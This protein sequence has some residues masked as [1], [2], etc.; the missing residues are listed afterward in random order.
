MR[1]KYPCEIRDGGR[2]ATER[3]LS[4]IYTRLPYPSPGAVLASRPGTRSRR[5]ADTEGTIPWTTRVTMGRR[6]LL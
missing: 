2:N 5:T 3:G 1:V 6:L 4:G